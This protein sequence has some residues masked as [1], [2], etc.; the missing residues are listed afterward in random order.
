[1]TDNI[2]N[3]HDKFFK[4]TMADVRVAKDFFKRYLPKEIL[5]QLDLTS[6]K[7]Y[8]NDFITPGYKV[9]EGEESYNY[10]TDFYEL[11]GQQKELM[12]HILNQPI[13]LIDVPRMEMMRISKSHSGLV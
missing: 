3:K 11:F 1:M 10:S 9:H 13:K 7:L 2:H 5:K 6:M 12:R 8:P 4:D